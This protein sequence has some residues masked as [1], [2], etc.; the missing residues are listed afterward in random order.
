MSNLRKIMQK[1]AHNQPEINQIS[2]QTID[3]REARLRLHLEAYQK[4]LVNCTPAMLQ[5][6]LAWLNEHIATL[7][8]CLNQPEML[9]AAGGRFQVEQWLAESRQCKEALQESMTHRGVAPVLH[10]HAVA[11]GEHAWELRE[12]RI[13]KLWGWT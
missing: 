11:T 8:L 2:H 10:P 4:Q 6:E 7:E 9:S 3:K 12:E 13:K 5:Y 1:L